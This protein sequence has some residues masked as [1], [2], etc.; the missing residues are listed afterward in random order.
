MRALIFGSI[1]YLRKPPN[2]RQ[3]YNGAFAAHVF[4]YIGMSRPIASFW[5]PRAATRLRGL[6]EGGLEAEISRIHETK[7]R[8]FGDMLA[9]GVA[10]RPGIIDSLALARRQGLKIGFV[11]TTTLGRC[12]LS[13]TPLPVRLIF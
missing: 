3:A 6:S 5:P 2:Q 12:S 11:T 8:I 13:R 4:D 1:G 10:A 7:Q 9:S